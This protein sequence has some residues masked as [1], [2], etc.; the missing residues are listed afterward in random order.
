[1]N[2]REV[3]PILK[4]MRDIYAICFR[5]IAYNNLIEEFEKELVRIK[6]KP[7]FGIRCQN[8]IKKLEKGD[9]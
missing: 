8:L 4:E 1:M 5:V 2:T 3:L 9:K 7:G 6:I